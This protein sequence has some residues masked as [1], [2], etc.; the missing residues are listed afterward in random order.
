[1]KSTDYK[2]FV[3]SLN[4]EDIDFQRLWLT[5][6]RRWLPATG[7]FVAVLILTVPSAFLR[8]PVYQ[9]TGKLLIKQ[10]DT[11]SLTGVGIQ[12]KELAPLTEQ[13]NPLKTET[14]VILSNALLNKTIVAL[15]LHD[16]QGNLL[17]A[18][19]VKGK[20]KVAPIAGA[21]V[22]EI[23]YQGTDPQEAAAV[24]NKLMNVYIEN[25]ILTNRAEAVAAGEF[26]TQ[27]LPKTEATVRQAE[28]AL[29]R[30]KEANHVADLDKEATSTVNTVASLDEQLTTARTELRNAKS[31]SKA[32]RN[33]L[34]MNSQ[35]AVAASS[36]SQ[37]P[38][39]QGVLEEF[40]EVERQ[41]AVARASYQEEHP[42][43]A[44]LESKE[45]KL[46]ALLQ[47]QTHQVLGIQKQQPDRK[48][49]IRGLK[50][51]L[52]SD[53][54]KLEVENIGLTTQIAALAD[55]KLAYEQ[56]I[57]V[58]PR[59][60]EEQRQLGRQL[61]AAQIT[62][63]TLLQKLQ[64]LRVIEIQ[65]VGNARII[66]TAV[67]PNEPSLSKTAIVLTLGGVVL[68]ILL[69]AA[70][71]IILEIRDKSV[72]TVKEAR[73]LLGYTLLGTIP[74]SGKSGKIISGNGDLE[75]SDS[76]IIVRDSPRSLIS[77][78][79]RMIQANLKF[80]RSDKEVKAILVTSS[81]PKEGKSTVT[82]NL[83]AVMAKLGNRVLLVD[84]DMRHPF[85]HH[86]WELTNQVGLSNMLVG[87][88]ELR[89]AAKEVMPNL[90]VLPSGVM[91][92]D[93]LALIDSKR[94]ASLIE[95]FSQKYD[96][97]IIDTPP[98]L[99]AA[100]ALVLGKMTDGVLFVARPGVV[101][102]ASAAAS[103]ESLEKSGQ[104]VLGLVVNGVIPKN[105]PDSYFYYAKEYYTEEDSTTLEKVS[106]KQI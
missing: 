40:Q 47:K 12:G 52:T 53:L 57:N 103:K 62:Y 55:E 68:G 64:E 16:Q 34:G 65:K 54:A 30:F 60:E 48:L 46:K 97:V 8:K 38:A 96:F 105:E 29:R 100:D 31:R 91:P 36:L 67:V 72:K 45:T 24:V 93:P 84:A 58:L 81:V 18:Q 17:S 11:P 21:D 4:P 78:V 71:I 76:T 2:V 61:E 82:A 6:K 27:Q 19:L 7:V 1:M 59:L 32:L 26:I 51:E 14:E 73:G 94:M 99:L 49:Q 25:D 5:L 89:T 98:L 43:V 35:E 77:E 74:F 9:T 22:I 106:S 44:E 10:N 23:S 104:S 13:G 85:Q 63:E 90:D 39:V 102:S 66:D 56:R 37:S 92:P 88:A 50:E 79:Y 70:T 69:S 101:D 86:M 95:S 15:N 41:L 20:L 42:I 87:Q 83:A 3:N 75:Q 80:L 33:Q 28:A